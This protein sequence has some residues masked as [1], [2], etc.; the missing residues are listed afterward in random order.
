MSSVSIIGVPPAQHGDGDPAVG[1]V[2]DRL[3]A[4]A[5]PRTE[6]GLDLA[7]W[8][9]RAFGDDGAFDLSSAV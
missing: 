8:V 6:S 2:V 3:A 9:F 5:A 4:A 1:P 7:W